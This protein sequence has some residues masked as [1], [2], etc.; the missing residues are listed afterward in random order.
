MKPLNINKAGC[1]NMSSNCVIWEGPDIPC[2][3][4]CKGDSI[5][6]VIYKLATELCKLLDIVD[7]STYDL[8][9]FNHLCLVSFSLFLDPIF[10]KYII[11]N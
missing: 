7:L 9:C 11:I 1:T 10:I 3:N 6:D 8:K 4:L 2:I 5:T